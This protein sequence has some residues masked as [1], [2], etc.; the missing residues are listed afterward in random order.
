MDRVQEPIDERRNELPIGL[1]K[2]LKG[3][4]RAAKNTPPKVDEGVPYEFTERY[5]VEKLRAVISESVF[6][7]K[8][9]FFE[10][11]GEQTV[12]A[13]EQ[14]TP[15]VAVRYETELKEH[16]TLVYESVL[17]IFYAT[18]TDAYDARVRAVG[19]RLNAAGGFRLMQC[20]YYALPVA[21]AALQSD[22]LA[23]KPHLLSCFY[24]E[25]N[26]VFHGIGRWVC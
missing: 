10:A 1:A 2:E 21:V 22:V 6:P 15:T 14:A 16:G 11:L 26:H 7:S 12:G 3:E 19:E 20:A 25:V 4:W 17:R 8:T 18:C 23:E 13:I 5:E 24:A 9:A